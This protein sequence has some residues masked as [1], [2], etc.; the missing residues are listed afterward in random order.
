M[1]EEGGRSAIGTSFSAHAWTLRQQGSS[2]PGLWG[3]VQTATA[4]LDSR[5]WHG[6]PPLRIPWLS[7]PDTPV[8]TGVAAAEGPATK[9]CLLPPPPWQSTHNTF[10]SARALATTATYLCTAKGPATSSRLLS[11]LLCGSL[12]LPRA[13]GPGAICMCHPLSLLLW[14][15]TQAIHIHI[16]HQGDNGLYTLRKGQHLNQKQPSCQKKSLNP[17]KLLMEAPEGANY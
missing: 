11:P 1:Q 13:Q 5:G 15:H 9:H 7:L 12:P 6:P 14:K 8:T 2:L 3:W 17:Y 16:P 10:A 4:I